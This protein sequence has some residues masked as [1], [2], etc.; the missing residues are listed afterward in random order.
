MSK[1]IWL[2][3]SAF[4]LLLFLSVITYVAVSIWTFSDDNQLTKKDAAIVLGAAVWDDE[5]S[6][7]FR[8]RIH[9]A[10][11]L[12]DNHYV[13]KIIFTG[14]KGDGARFAESEVAKTYAIEK[15][16]A[17]EDI[18]IETQSRITEQNLQYAYEIAK[19]NE[20]YSFTIVSDPL[21]MK[22]AMLMAESLGMEA[23]ASPTE[24]TV[25]KTFKSKIPFLC[26][27]VFFYIG[28]VLTLPFR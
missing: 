19:E 4:I 11:W 6:P 17:E 28:Y 3:A 8:E 10:I 21:H 2:K 18:L 12:Y 15:G 26:R 5:P 27:E 23:Y 7:V 9:H 1:K 14:G 13:E 25:Y 24:T 22:R 20:L 16:V